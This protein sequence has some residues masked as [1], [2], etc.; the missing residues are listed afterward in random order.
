[1]NCCLRVSALC[2]L[3]VGGYNAQEKVSL[4]YVGPTLLA[5]RQAVSN[6]LGTFL[7]AAR[8][9]VCYTVDVVVNTQEIVSGFSGDHS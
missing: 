2:L 7:L 4:L 8:I 6:V 9:V 3:R 5:R 1:M